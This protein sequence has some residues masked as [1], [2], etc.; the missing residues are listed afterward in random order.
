MFNPFDFIGRLF[1]GGGESVYN[2]ITQTRVLEL[3]YQVTPNARLNPYA[4]GVM[5]EFSSVA[6]AQQL[7]NLIQA[8]GVPVTQ[9][10]CSVV[11]P[12][13]ALDLDGGDD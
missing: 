3:A 10:G 1:S 2:T 6:E 13:G 12:F 7:V 11:I 4:L 8:E 9:Q 5:I